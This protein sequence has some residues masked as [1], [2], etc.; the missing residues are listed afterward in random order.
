MEIFRGL[1]SIYYLIAVLGAA[2]ALE[3][4]VPWRR[5]AR[6]DFVRWIRNAAMLFYSIIILSLLPAISGYGVAFAAEAQSF[7]LFNQFAV[8]F[9]AQLVLAFIALD[10][11]VYVEHRLLHALYVLWRTHRV[12]H[13]DRHIDASTSVRFHPFENIFRAA[14]EA[15]LIFVLGL[16]AEGVLLTFALHTLAN[17]FTHCN[18]RAPLAMEQ[19]VS[20][21]FITPRMHRVHHS[22]APSNLNANFGTMLSIWDR[23]FGTL[24]GPSALREDEAFGIEGPE[25]I[26]ED[27]FGNLALDPFRRP[28]GGAIP[29]PQKTGRGR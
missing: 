1:T 12:H 8:A 26:A 16:P 29:K 22:T 9:W 10:L 25:Q 5:V 21:I 17:S 18:V 15:P 4:I 2:I 23:L 7:G 14:F 19:V 24:T 20:A 11:F 28:E 6:I 27:T 3:L 13:S